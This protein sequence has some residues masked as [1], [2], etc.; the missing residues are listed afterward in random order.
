M[1]Q[2][3][4][5]NFFARWLRWRT[6]GFLPEWLLLLLLPPFLRMLA[7]C[8]L[9][10]SAGLHLADL[11]TVLLPGKIHR[12]HINLVFI[13]HHIGN[14]R[15]PPFGCQPFRLLPAVGHTLFAL[16]QV[17]IPADG[18]ALSFLLHVLIRRCR[19]KNPSIE[20]V[21]T[22][23]FPQPDPFVRVFV[24]HATLSRLGIQ[25]DPIPFLAYL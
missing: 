7:P 23:F 11:R 2:C 4:F 16:F 13:R 1:R 17:L 8:R 9:D 15:P 25:N 5:L 18:Y 20:N 12:P 24:Q 14:L 10:S 19:R 3:V 6:G 21:D 22:F